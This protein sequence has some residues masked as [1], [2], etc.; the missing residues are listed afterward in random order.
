MIDRYGEG[1]AALGLLERRWF[2]SMSAARALQ[3]ECEVLRGVMELAE[4]AWRRARIELARLEE[5][6]D[7]LGEELADRDRLLDIPSRDPSS[8]RMS[9]AA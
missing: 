5:I 2:A 6:R 9:S 7:A 3:A 8:C 1:D 4:G